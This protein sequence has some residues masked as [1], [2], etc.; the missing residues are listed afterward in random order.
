MKLTSI[1]TQLI[2]FLAGFMIFLSG[3][4]KDAIFLLTAFLAVISAIVMDSAL[5]Y[6]KNRK[7]ILTDSS[8]IS[9]LIIGYVLSAAQPWWIYPLASLF[10]IGSKHLVQVNGKHIFNPAALGI[11]LTILFFNATTQWKGTYFWYILL[12][13]G[14]YFAYKVRKIEILI[15]YALAFLILFGAQALL[16]KI[17]LLNI[18]GYLSYF[19]IFVMVIEPKTTPI[20]PL[21]KLIFGIGVLTLIFIFTELGVGF[22]AELFALLVFNSALPILNKI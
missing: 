3:K 10:A 11:F 2:I 17:N 8:V 21:G 14:A 15:G 16:Q 12:P 9:G 1:K 5:L 4:D 19:Y 20:K 22:D 7:L 18:L 6:F 13:A